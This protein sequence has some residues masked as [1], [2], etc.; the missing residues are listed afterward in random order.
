MIL[1]PLR[2]PMYALSTPFRPFLD[3]LRTIIGPLS[4]HQHPSAPLG[5]P[6]RPSAPLGNPRQ[7]SEL[8]PLILK[9][10][11]SYINYSK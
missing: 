3:T 1:T 9:I 11:V 10:K 2:L 4:T 5:A 6:R 8:H 7:P